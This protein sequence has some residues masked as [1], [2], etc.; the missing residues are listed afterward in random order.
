MPKYQ[1]F[2]T[3]MLIKIKCLN[4]L[5]SPFSDF[6]YR[7]GWSLIDMANYEAKITIS[8]YFNK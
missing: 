5:Q 4:H 7:E 3:H 6:Q 8:G 2:A 1:L